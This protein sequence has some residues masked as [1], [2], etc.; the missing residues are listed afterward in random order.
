MKMSKFSEQHVVLILKQ[1]DD[2]LGI[3]EVCRKAGVSL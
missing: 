3:D 2:G 1:V